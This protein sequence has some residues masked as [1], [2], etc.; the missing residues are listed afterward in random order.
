VPGASP[1]AGRARPAGHRIGPP[2]KKEPSGRAA[3]N[4]FLSGAP[5]ILLKDAAGDALTIYAAGHRIS[6]DWFF[7][8]GRRNTLAG[9]VLG[10]VSGFF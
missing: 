9:S 10:L 6:G 8:A 4:D 3:G 5:Q 7:Y 2:N 1:V